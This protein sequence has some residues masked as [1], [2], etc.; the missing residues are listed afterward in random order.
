VIDFTI[1]KNGDIVNCHII[2]E[3]GERSLDLSA[4]AAIDLSNPF[5]RL[6]SGFSGDELQLRFGF[7][8]NIPVE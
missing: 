7:Y 5:Q 8:Y 4:K 2:S 3:S 6:P 1:A